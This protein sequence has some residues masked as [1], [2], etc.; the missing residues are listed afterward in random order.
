MIDLR[1]EWFVKELKKMSGVEIYL[2]G[3]CVRDK[4]LGL[5]PKDLDIMVTGISMY[6]LLQV[7]ERF[8][9]AKL[10]GKSFG[11]VKFTATEP[12]AYGKTIDIALPRIDISTGTGHKDFQ[13][14]AG[15][16][17]SLEQDLGRRD[18]TINAIA[19]TLDGKI[20]DP[21]D[22]KVDIDDAILRVPVSTKIFM[23]DPL[24]ML[25]AIRFSARFGFR[26]ELYLEEAIQ[27]Q[28]DK[29]RKISRERIYEEI[30]LAYE[31]CESNEQLVDYISMLRNCFFMELS[32]RAEKLRFQ[33]HAHLTFVEFMVLL[34][35]EGLPF[36]A[37]DRIAI[38][39]E[40]I[41][42]MKV[43]YLLAEADNATLEVTKRLTV[44]EAYKL[45]DEIDCETFPDLIYIV[46]EFEKGILPKSRKQLAMSG[47]SFAFEVKNRTPAALFK[48]SH[49]SEHMDKVL[50]LI[51]SG[52]LENTVD[53]ITWYLNQELGELQKFYLD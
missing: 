13:V 32:M 50:K 33:R 40:V 9:D 35:P 3:G 8:G 25:R 42:E 36:S 14:I 15:K 22:G 34:Y 45:T 38:P 5:D 1:R 37:L 21:Y 7:L 11:V 46:E 28:H 12:V 19:M 27:E 47:E 51:V 31:Q 52:M 39:N 24:R 41:N 23:E 2:V 6:E 53:S 26:I 10:V 43:M 44:L 48:S 20:I 29:I 4:I 16:E 17:V 49:I 30:K 18:L